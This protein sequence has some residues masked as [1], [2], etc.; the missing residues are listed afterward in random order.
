MVL[1]KGSF[2]YSSL[3]D[4]GEYNCFFNSS[5]TYTELTTDWHPLGYW[6]GLIPAWLILFGWLADNKFGKYR[7]AKFGLCTLFIGTLSV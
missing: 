3:D 6:V 1:F 7:V 2:S 5:Y 4:F